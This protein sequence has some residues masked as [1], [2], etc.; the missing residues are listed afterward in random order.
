MSDDVSVR[1]GADTSELNAGANQASEKVHDFANSVDEARNEI[2]DFKE[3]L[4]EAFAIDKIINFIDKMSE[5]GEQIE[6]SATMTALSADQV[7]T[8][9]FA[10]A[11]T[12]GNAE[13][14]TSVMSR[15]ERN[16]LAASSGAGSAY[17]A[18]QRMGISLD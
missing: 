2:R 7:Q 16:V 11:M 6:R 12:G 13:E 18:F 4:I 15:F 8:L 14:A 5:V 9:G 1:F 17:E 10:M 3:L